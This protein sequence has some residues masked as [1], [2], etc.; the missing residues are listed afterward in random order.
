MIDRRSLAEA[1]RAPRRQGRPPCRR[2]THDDSLC[3]AFELR[4]WTCVLITRA[5]RCGQSNSSGQR[6]T[7]RVAIAESELPT[8]IPSYAGRR[9]QQTD[10]ARHHPRRGAA[11]YRAA[12][13]TPLVR[14]DCRATRPARRSSSSSRRC[15]RSAPSRS[16]ARRTRS[17]AA[18]RP[19]SPHGVWTV[20]A[21]NAAQG[22]ALAARLAGA[23]CS[24]MV[25]DTAPETKLRAIERLGATIVK[26]PYDECWRTVEQHALR[27]DARPL[28]PS[29][30]RRRL[31]LR[32]G[33][34][35]PRDP[36]GPARRRRGRRA[37]RRRRPAGRYRR[38]RC[39]ALRPDARVYAAEPE[40]AAPL[41]A[42]LA[43]RA[44]RAASTAGR[45]RSS[46]A[47]A[48]SRCCR[49]CG[50]C[51][52]AWVR[53][54][55]RRLARRRG[56]GDAA[57]SPNARTSSPKGAA[58]CAVAAAL[59]PALRARGHQQGCRGRVGRQHRSRRA[60]PSSSAR[61]R[62]DECLTRVV[63]VLPSATIR[64]P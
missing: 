4:H 30:R 54:L 57:R 45:R 36:R 59:S 33:T 21:G 23:P 29:V 37:A 61:C 20:S 5:F 50:R 7:R 55:D 24:V 1:R 63:E 56:A 34:I 35:G 18:P 47:P 62:S 8:T 11:V 22:V 26:A 39:D 31:H 53:R 49:R 10:L 13:R 41:A 2:R 15:S 58:A 60:S 51:C 12:V 52:S 3:A 17:P 9:D 64:R 19:S 43:R 27:S 44:S 6:L 38:A 48:A 46:T 28:R 25:M 14:L 40:T 16:A 32:N 42:S